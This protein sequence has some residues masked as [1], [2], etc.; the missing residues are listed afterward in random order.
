MPIVRPYKR[1]CRQFTDNTYSHSG[2]WRY[3]VHEKFAN[4]PAHY[5]RAF[6]LIQKDL[7]KLFDYIEP[8][9]Q[10]LETYSFRIHELLVR[11]CIEI[12]ANC[13]AILT[14][15]GYANTGRL[16]MR[17]YKKINLSHRLSSYEVYLPIW[18][19]DQSKRAPYKN[20]I[21]SGSLPWYQTYNDTK[22]DRHTKFH[23]ATFEHLTDSVCGLL[24]LLSAQFWTE[25]YSSGNTLLAIEGPSDGTESAI[26]GEFRIRFP[27]D[28]PESE[29]YEFDWER[30]EHE[31]DPFQCFK[32]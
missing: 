25:D 11:T 20:W 29:K 19:G 4:S 16:D 22:H 8:A 32:Y 3:L 26:G 21:N 30:I 14:E 7:I 31:E 18:K 27:T 17:D 24:A 15:N 5:I 10:N 13:K 12:E 28:W 2:K 9:D 1:T 23:H 6:L